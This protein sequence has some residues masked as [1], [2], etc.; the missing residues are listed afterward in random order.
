MTILTFVICKPLS[1][2][3]FKL[4]LWLHSPERSLVNEGGS[5][6]ADAL[7]RRHA[8]LME[9][10]TGQLRR[11]AK[12][13]HGIKSSSIDNALEQD[14]TQ[15]ALIAL[16]LSHAVEPDNPHE[17]LDDIE[18]LSAAEPAPTVRATESLEV[19]TFTCRVWGN[20]F[21]CKVLRFKDSTTIGDAALPTQGLHRRRSTLTALLPHCFSTVISLA[22]VLFIASV[23]R[24]FDSG[25]TIGWLKAATQALGKHSHY[26]RAHC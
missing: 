8:E 4:Y 26:H 1:M 18:E 12:K 14:N 13:A 3:L 9:L 11:Q 16:L 7:C 6:T 25:R 23:T 24:N 2:L 19:V 22:C 17:L 10:K 21:C 15:Q 20:L 5:V